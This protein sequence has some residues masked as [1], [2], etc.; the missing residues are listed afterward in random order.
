MSTDAFW[1]IIEDVHRASGGDMNTKCELLRRQL[2]SLSPD[3]LRCFVQNFDECDARAYNQPLWGAIYSLRGGCSDDSFQD[4][5]ATLI[6]LG[7]AAFE[8]ALSKPDDLA[9]LELPEDPC[10]EGF[11]YV[12]AQVARAVLGSRRFKSEFPTSPTGADWR[13]EQLPLLYPKLT[14][15]NKRLRAEHRTRRG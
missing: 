13:E 2:T 10:F 6:S 3:E 8:K 4:F 11:Q 9:D 15:L 14:A 12:P 5:R 7:R 1:K